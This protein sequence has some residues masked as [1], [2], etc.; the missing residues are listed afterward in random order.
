MQLQL[1]VVYT[2]CPLNRKHKLIPAVNS[3][4]FAPRQFAQ[5][6]ITLARL[7][8]CVGYIPKHTDGKSAEEIDIN[9]NLKGSHLICVSEKQPVTNRCW[10][11]LFD[12]SQIRQF[13]SI[14]KHV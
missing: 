7:F 12:E 9:A 3:L 10:V 5:S 14:I 6:I 11:E 2:G 8:N 4:G 13:V 1:W